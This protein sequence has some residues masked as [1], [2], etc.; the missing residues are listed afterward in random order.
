V[1][2]AVAPGAGV[3]GAG[4]GAIAA[5]VGA[6]AAAVVAASI[7]KPGG[8]KQAMFLPWQATTSSSENTEGNGQ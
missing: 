2:A 5:A 7:G 3:A 8:R 6:G 4:V 1:V